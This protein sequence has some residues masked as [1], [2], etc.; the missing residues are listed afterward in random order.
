MSYTAFPA[1]DLLAAADEIEL[2]RRM[3]AGALAEEALRSRRGFPGAT[4]AELWHLV[5]EG[6]AARERFLLANLRLVA[7]VSGRAARQSGLYAADLFQEGVTG[8]IQAVDRYDHSQGVRFASYALPWIRAIIARAVANRFGALN[9]SGARAERRRQLRAAWRRLTQ[10]LGREPSVAEVAAEVGQHADRVA[11][12]LDLQPPCALVD[13][14]GYVIDPPDVRASEALDRVVETRLP[15]ETWVR[16][17]PARQRRV[18]ELRF[19][20]DRDPVSYQSIGQELGVSSSTV[21]RLERSALDLLRDSC[22]TE[23]LAMVG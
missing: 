16:R 6:E 18:V 22:S 4:S 10:Q 1:V 19:G 8:L 7:M 9:L 15:L 13:D 5:R 2:A 21:R 12:L 14:A 20:F 17:L 23:E 11:E 3:E